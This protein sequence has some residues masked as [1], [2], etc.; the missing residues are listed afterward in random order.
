MVKNR[1]KKSTKIYIDKQNFNLYKIEWSDRRSRIIR[2]IV[3]DDWII[4]N[5]IDFFTTILY[6]DVKNESKITCKLSEIDFNKIDDNDI[7][8]IK[9]GF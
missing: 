4:K 5:N 8:V 7:N 6:E 9:A 3:F 2:K 1:K